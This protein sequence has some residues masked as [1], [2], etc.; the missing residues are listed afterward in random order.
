MDTGR[1]ETLGLAPLK[2]RMDALYGVSDRAAFTRFMGSTKAGFG[3]S[4]VD[5]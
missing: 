2:P 5:W 4:I 3:S 1:L